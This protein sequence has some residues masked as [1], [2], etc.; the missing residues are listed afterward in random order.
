MSWFVYVVAQEQ[1]D[2]GGMGIAIT[3]FLK[4][5]C[6]SLWNYVDMY[7]I[8]QIRQGCGAYDSPPTAVRLHLTARI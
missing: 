1:S 7:F 5:L 3:A 8:A 6:G 2:H 4:I